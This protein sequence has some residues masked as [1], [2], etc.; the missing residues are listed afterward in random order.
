MAQT[1]Y[2]HTKPVAEEGRTFFVWRT[3]FGVL[4]LSLCMVASASAKT[5]KTNPPRKPATLPVTTSSQAARQ[6]FENG[7]LN[8]E[9]LRLE[10]ALKD[11][12]GSAKLDP[13]FVLAHA[14][15]FFTTTDPAEE[16]S[17]RARAKASMSRATP[18][19]QLMVR[20]MVGVRENNYMGGIAAMN[21]LLAQYPRDKRLA[22]LTGRWVMAQRQYEGSQRLM[23]RAL[24]VDPD[25][26]AALNE[27]GYT[28]A[29]MGEY[30]KALPVME[31]YASV[32]P[33][34]PNP[35]DSYAE[36]M[37]MAGYYQGALLH[38]REALK[39]TPDFVQSQV[40]IAD[41]YSLTGDQETARV[42]YAKAI[43]MGKTA[44]TKLDYMLRSAVTYVREKKFAKADEAFSEAA[45]KAHQDGLP[46][47][48]A[49]A[50]RMMAMY[51]PDAATSLK[52]LEDAE[53]VLR[54][55][56]NMAQSSLDEEKARI[57]RVR[58][59]RASAASNE[60][61]ASAALAD[62]QK[63][64]A[65]D[66]NAAVQRSYHA[67]NG[68]LLVLQQKYSDA[69]PHLEEDSYDPFSLKLLALAYS[70][71]GILDEAKTTNKKLL[72]WNAPTIEQAL[73]VPELRVLEQQNA[74]LERR[75]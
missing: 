8:Y 58:V 23:L 9:N 49:R 11:W 66:K 64:A 43:Q 47:W 74:K 67:A 25:Y 20:W 70:K 75:H 72:G 17:E 69:I 15:I 48:E 34:E 21:D 68:A 18:D 36:I 22:Y 10:D 12:R 60:S 29:R 42:E 65:S 24:D 14:W 4:A 7:M 19:E 13:K 56:G 54:A 28:F 57:L 1:S 40:G 44:G 63:L 32:L 52:H 71:T 26:A 73:V 46:I 39:I 37:R 33:S 5:K 31:K 50:N 41:T 30:D 3:I 59:E 27:L 62:L 38:F 6:Y 61:L 45:K 53:A 2:A 35:Q 55:R 51:E 16:N